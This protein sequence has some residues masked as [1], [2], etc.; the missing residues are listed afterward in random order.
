ML[1]GVMTILIT[2]VTKGS[3]YSVTSEAC[4]LILSLHYLLQS[5]EEFS[6]LFMHNYDLPLLDGKFVTLVTPPHVN[7][8]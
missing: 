7:C 1:T 8:L 4:N 2:S 6:T 5:Y 3:S